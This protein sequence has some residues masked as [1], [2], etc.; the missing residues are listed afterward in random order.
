MEENCSEI[1][2]EISS[3]DE[4]MELSDSSEGA[5]M[6]ESASEEEEECCEYSI[7][8]CSDNSSEEVV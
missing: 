7:D 3:D 2:E 1:C 8:D 6:I 4:W 5:I